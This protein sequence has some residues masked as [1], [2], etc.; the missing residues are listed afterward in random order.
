MPRRRIHAS[1]TKILILAAQ[2][3]SMPLRGDRSRS[4]AWR[5]KMEFVRF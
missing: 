5:N 1:M 4:E 3:I 2:L